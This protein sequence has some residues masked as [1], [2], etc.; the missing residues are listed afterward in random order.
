MFADR[1]KKVR[2]EAGYTQES[3]AQALGVSK[4]TVAMWETGKRNP[5]FEM[6]C[7][8]SDLLDRKVDYLLDHSDDDSSPKIT[9]EGVELLG[10]WEAESQFVEALK[11][12]MS[13]DNYGRS[14]VDS[15]LRSERLRCHEQGTI[16]D[17][18]GISVA[19]R[20]N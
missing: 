15:V 2:K 7:D 5:D 13:L 4:G 10:K 8:I 16:L 6:L 1:L 3:L 20:I 14:T 17:T 12:Y 9:E 11:M 19:V 18:S